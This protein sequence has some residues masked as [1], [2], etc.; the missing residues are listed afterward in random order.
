MISVS[1]LGDDDDGK[2]DG[3]YLSASGITFL[4]LVHY[5]HF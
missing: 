1:G 4:P 2:N 5:R 3:L